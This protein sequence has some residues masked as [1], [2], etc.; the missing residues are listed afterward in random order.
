MAGLLPGSGRSLAFS[1]KDLGLQ[2]SEAAIVRPYVIKTTRVPAHGLLLSQEE[3]LLPGPDMG[4]E[5]P[6][7]CRPPSGPTRCLVWP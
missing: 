2:S 5:A 1:R 4:E 6:G 3:T 7:P